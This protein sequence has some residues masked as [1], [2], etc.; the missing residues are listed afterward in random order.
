M[1]G[2]L[3]AIGAGLAVAAGLVLLWVVIW[4]L[5]V[6]IGGLQPMD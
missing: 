2:W 1:P 4:G 5:S 3:V 6:L